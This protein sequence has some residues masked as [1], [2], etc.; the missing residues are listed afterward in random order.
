M[1]KAFRQSPPPN[2]L[3]REEMKGFE[4]PPV[5][6]GFASAPRKAGAKHRERMRPI[7][8]I[9]PCRHI[10]RPPIRSEAYESRPIQHG[11]PKNIINRKFVHTA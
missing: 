9:H 4:E 2:V 8:L 3:D 11:N 5:V 10:I 7:F 6:L 1:T